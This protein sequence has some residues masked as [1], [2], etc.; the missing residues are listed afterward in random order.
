MQQLQP[1]DSASVLAR[2]TA[3][4]GEAIVTAAHAGLACNHVFEAE[5]LQSTPRPVAP[6]RI[7]RTVRWIAANTVI[8]SCLF[9]FQ[10]WGPTSSHPWFSLTA[11]GTIL[12]LAAMGIGSWAVCETLWRRERR[13]L[14]YG[15]SVVAHV[16][17]RVVRTRPGARP[18]VTLRYSYESYT[19]EIVHDCVLVKQ[20]NPLDAG[21]AFTLLQDPR[22]PRE[23]LPYFAFEAARVKGHPC[24]NATISSQDGR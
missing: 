12:W 6:T 17:E 7:T 1:T 11:T 23:V 19:G 8:A 10:K 15:V 3:T 2:A 21:D 13:L 5:L 20:S 14:A 18:E 4:Q 22:E 9:A 24:A 16:T